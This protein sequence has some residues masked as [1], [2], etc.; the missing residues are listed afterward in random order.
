MIHQIMHSHVAVAPAAD[1]AER[2]AA[3]PE[4]QEGG[5]YSRATGNPSITR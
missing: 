5:D 1:S 3:L 2:C 4:A